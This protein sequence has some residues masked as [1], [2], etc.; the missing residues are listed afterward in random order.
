MFVSSSLPE[1][2]IR[3]VTNL[4]LSVQCWLDMFATPQLDSNSLPVQNGDVGLLLDSFTILVDSMTLN[5]QCTN[6]TSPSLN[7]LPE[8]F[9]TLKDKFLRTN[10]ESSLDFS[11][12]ILKFNNSGLSL[13]WSYFKHAF[14]IP[15]K[16]FEDTLQHLWTLLEHFWD[17]FLYFGVSGHIL[18]SLLFFGACIRRLIWE[19][20]CW[21]I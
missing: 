10:D 16:R 11:N 6:C 14:E 4:M 15:S 21:P 8:L 20:S 17:T 2:N 7:I 1:G 5:A 18:C 19:S 12:R 13:C 9:Q 3:F